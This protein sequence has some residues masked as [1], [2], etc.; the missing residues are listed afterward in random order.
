MV[1][2]S[3][4][5]EQLVGVLD[6]A[7]QGDYPGIACSTSSCKLLKII[8]LSG[9]KAL[10]DQ[11]LLDI[12]SMCSDIRILEQGDMQGMRNVKVF[13]RTNILSPVTRKGGRAQ[14]NFHIK[15]VVRIWG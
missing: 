15:Y 7:M 14:H 13:I 5:M 10:L 9:M 12:R 8:F 11:H 4:S 6:A 1:T 3:I 2:K